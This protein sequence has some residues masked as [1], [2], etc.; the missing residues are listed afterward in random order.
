MESHMVAQM[1]DCKIWNSD[2]PDGSL[3]MYS[4]LCNFCHTQNIFTRKLAVCAKNG[5]MFNLT[6][7]G[8]NKF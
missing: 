7:I 5:G 3:D 6:P 1:G 4:Q 2:L 8:A